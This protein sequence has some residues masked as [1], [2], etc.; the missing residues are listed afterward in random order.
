MRVEPVVA[1]QTSTEARARRSA[2]ASDTPIYRMVARALE[3]HRIEGECVVDV[4]CGTG[5]LYPW[6]K[7]RGRYVGVDLVRY[8]GFPPEAEFVRSD[9]AIPVPPRSADLVVAVETI[10]HL[11]NPALSCAAW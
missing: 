5:N 10:E 9:L 8:D 11:K 1:C 4:G 3:R 2:G 6:V 7:P